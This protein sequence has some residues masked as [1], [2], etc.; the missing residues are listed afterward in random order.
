MVKIEYRSPSIDNQGKLKFNNFELKIDEDLKIMLNTYH[1]YET[2]CQIEVDAIVAIFF[3]DIIKM[4]KLPESSS[5]V[6][7]LFMLFSC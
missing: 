1:R 2:K 5:N 3:D 7:V 4:L 6:Q